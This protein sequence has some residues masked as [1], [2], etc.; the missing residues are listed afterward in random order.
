MAGT[1]VPVVYGEKNR[2][3]RTLSLWLHTASSVTAAATT[4]VA[5]SF[6]GRILINNPEERVAMIVLAGV[7]VI[8]S[9]RELGILRV[10]AP[11]RY[12]QVP[13]TWRNRYNPR[14]MSVLFGASL[15]VGLLTRIHVTT[16]YVLPLFALLSGR[17][18]DGVVA[19]ALF[20]FSRSL[21]LHWIIAKHIQ[22][23]EPLEDLL[24]QIQALEP[25]MRVINGVLLALG[26]AV[27]VGLAVDKF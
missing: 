1:I 18:A 2:Q 10:P 8:Y 13:A 22:P 26:G 24:N 9:L 27:L 11:Q 4:A 12:R 3:E 15:G 6:L 7:A 19:F 25:V 21:P 17:L 14:I 20:G 23:G 5:L 16:F